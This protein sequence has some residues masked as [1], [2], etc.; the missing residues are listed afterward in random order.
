MCRRST[1]GD[2]CGFSTRHPPQICRDAGDV[3]GERPRC[4]VPSLSYGDDAVMSALK[5]PSHNSEGLL[6]G[7]KA[8]LVEGARQGLPF[9]AEP[10]KFV[11]GC[12]PNFRELRIADE[13]HE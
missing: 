2:F 12:R 10:Y 5:Q 1:M 6:V 13:A 11:I 4:S 8:T 9:T 3:F 7:G